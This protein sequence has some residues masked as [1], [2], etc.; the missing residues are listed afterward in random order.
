[1]KLLLDTIDRLGGIVSRRQL[2][3]WGV[4]PGTIDL[5]AWY[6]WFVIRVRK[7]WYARADESS[8]V[9]RAWRVGG[10]LTCVSALA[11]H[12][13]EADGAV[14]HVEVVNGSCQLRDPDNATKRLGPDARVIVHW[15]RHPGPG[16]ERAV[17]EM[18]A[19]AVA[20]VCGTRGAGVAR[21]S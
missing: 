18:H 11:Y 4:D 8:D 15:T 14:L 2:L 19:V 16:T 9:L 13:G 1:M 12:A 5:A 17:T 10:R 6:G 21:P 3:A 7:G 20:A